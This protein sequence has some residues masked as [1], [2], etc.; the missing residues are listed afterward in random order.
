MAYLL[1]ENLYSK[2]RSRFYSDFSVENA[3]K[4]TLNETVN[5]QK[6]YSTKKYD[7]FLSHSS[8]D[9]SLILGVKYEL[10]EKGFSVYVDWIDDSE[11]DRSKV[12]AENAAMLRDRMRN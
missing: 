5:A 3:A 11:I 4:R 9:A 2:V 8:K 6:R 10:E 12:T 1:K 7:V